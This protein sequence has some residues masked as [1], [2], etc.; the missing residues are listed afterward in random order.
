MLACAS[1]SLFTFKE[2]LN[3]LHMKRVQSQCASRLKASEKRL[4]SQRKTGGFQSRVW[5]WCVRDLW[6]EPDGSLCN[7]Q[8]HPSGCWVCE[9][10]ELMFLDRD[11]SK[12]ITA[13]CVYYFS[14]SSMHCLQT[15]WTSSWLSVL[16]TADNNSFNGH[17]NVGIMIGVGIKIFC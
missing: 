12:L 2:N 15:R 11:T 10:V 9:Y 6:A 7:M 4:L 13:S 5:V 1:A 8:I 3:S 14:S 17:S 16:V